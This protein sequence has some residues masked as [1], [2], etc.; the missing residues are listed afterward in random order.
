MGKINSDNLWMNAQAGYAAYSNA[1]QEKRAANSAN[2]ES[3]NNLVKYLE[4]KPIAEPEGDTF[5]S[6]ISGTVPALAIFEAPRGLSWLKKAKGLKVDDALNVAK[7]AEAGK[8]A[9]SCAAKLKEYAAP[10]TDSL[11]N[12]FTGSGKVSQRVRNYFNSVNEFQNNSRQLTEAMKTF[13]KAEKAGKTVEEL[14]EAAKTA[15]GVAK[16]AEGVAKT[17]KIAGAVSKV[18]QVAGKPFAA[19][20]K[21][22]P[23]LGKVGKFFKGSGAAGFAVIG[24]GIELATEV[25]P[26]FKQLGAKA[27]IKQI[28]KS[29]VK[30][31]ADIGG[32]ALGAKGGAAVGAAIGSIFPGI[33]TAIGAA[34]GGFIGGFVGSWGA[35]KVAKAVTGPSER[36]IA[37]AKS[38][39]EQTAAILENSK[40]VESLKQLAFQKVQATVQQ[41]G[42]VDAESQKALEEIEKLNNPFAKGAIY[43]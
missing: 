13:R 4:N 41:N 37:Q 14:Q 19:A 25:V 28:G 30:V 12:V 34:I 42:Y 33:G 26:T 15:E 23:A 11:K 18:K 10:V 6:T 35:G 5:T 1:M 22:V 16:T 38:E 3:V 7:A 36:E 43:A 24:G 17:G 32:W 2:A 21:K 29:A 27:G 9:V 40:D 31:A 8:D 39:K 20:A